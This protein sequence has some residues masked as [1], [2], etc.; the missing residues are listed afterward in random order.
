M[1]FYKHIEDDTFR[2]IRDDDKLGETLVFER[3]KDSQ[4]IPRVKGFLGVRVGRG[5]HC[6]GERGS[7]FK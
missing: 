1:T 6:E 5:R 3:N 7:N 4:I 2:R